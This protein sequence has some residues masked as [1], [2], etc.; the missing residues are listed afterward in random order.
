MK[1][2][3]PERNEH[4]FNA[5]D[6]EEKK[7]KKLLTHVEQFKRTRGEVDTKKREEESMGINV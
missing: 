2:P 6:E 4:A 3:W 5:V 7:D 1:K